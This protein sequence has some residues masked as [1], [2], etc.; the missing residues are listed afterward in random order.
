MATEKD[1][2]VEAVR[3]EPDDQHKPAEPRK[4]WFSFRLDYYK[5]SGKWYGGEDVRFEVGAI[6]SG[7][8]F[9]PYLYEAVD[10][11]REMS[12]TKLPGLVGG[13]DGPIQIV[14]V[15]DDGSHGLSHLI[16]PD[17]MRRREGSD[18]L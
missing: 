14:S 9:I 4:L 11:V 7:D 16:V 12:R 18:R 8:G 15:E 1:E 2:M 17:D 10:M 6:P 13:W 3:I 5:P